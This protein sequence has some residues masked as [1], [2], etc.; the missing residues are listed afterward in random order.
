M[1]LEHRRTRAEQYRKH[2]E[3]HQE[4]G[5]LDAVIADILLQ[6]EEIKPQQYVDRDLGGAGGQERRNNVRC[7]GVGI[8][9]PDVQWK[10]GRFQ[11][12]ANHN[13]WVS[14]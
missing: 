13:V 9:Q 14:V 6:Y 11:R 10:Y 3:R 5:K 2:G 1:T 12:Q 7:V 8:W 4:K